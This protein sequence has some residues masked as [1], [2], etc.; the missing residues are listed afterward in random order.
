MSEAVRRYPPEMVEFTRQ[1]VAVPSENPPGN[2]YA[3]AVKVLSRH[4]EQL[5][6][7]PQIQGDCVLSFLGEGDRTLFFRGH[8]GVVPAQSPTQF[9]PFISGDNL[10][11]RG[12]SDMKSGLAAM[13]YAAKAVRESGASLNGRIGPVLVPDEET[14]GPM[15]S[16]QA[17][18]WVFPG[19]RFFKVSL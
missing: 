6:F 19:P 8:Y 17:R 10:F 12:S 4:L 5:G 2:H 9:E 16:A 15:V 13:I 18:T 11:E 3:E 1:L 7:E 14:A